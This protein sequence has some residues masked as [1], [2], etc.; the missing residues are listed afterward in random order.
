MRRRGGGG[1]RSIYRPL[2]PATDADPREVVR[3]RQGKGRAKSQGASFLGA[4]GAYSGSSR[5]TSDDDG[6]VAPAAAATPPQ[7]LRRAVSRRGYVSDLRGRSSKGRATAVRVPPGP[8]SLGAGPQRAFRRH[9]R[10]DELWA[11]RPWPRWRG[12]SASSPTSRS[13][14]SPFRP[15]PAASDRTVTLDSPRVS[16]NDIGNGIGIGVQD[17]TGGGR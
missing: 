13:A 2:N 1:R 4:P 3:R 16:G 9:P 8:R 11:C 6:G 12:G 14:C 10:P 15:G 7:R 17:A 5:W